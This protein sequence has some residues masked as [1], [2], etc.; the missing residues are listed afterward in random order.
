MSPAGGFWPRL[1]A[2]TRKEFR[3]M[4][5]DR[6]NL[7]IGLGLPIILI[8]LFGYG[9]SLDV[10]NTPVAIVLEDRSPQ[11][12]AAV[13][14]LLASSYIAPVLLPSMHEAEALM[15]ER[16]VDGILRLRSDFS[17]QLAAGDAHVQLLVHG[18]DANRARIVLAYVQGA[19]AQS[20][21][22][23]VDRNGRPA[24]G[25]QVTVEPQMWFNAASDS[26]W[27][28]V[29][30]LIVLI[31]TLVGAFLT[32]MVVAREWERGTL[33]A[34]FVTPVRPT[35]ILLAKLIPYFCVGMAG[36]TMCLLAAHFLFQVPCRGS[37]PLLVAGSVI[38]LLVALGMGLLI[39]S[40]TKNQFVASQ[41]ALVTS[42]MPA[43]MLSG[44]MFD[45]RSVP[46]VIRWVGNLLPATYYIELL[47]TLFLAGDVWPLLLKDLAV[48]T[49]YAAALLAAARM[50]TRKKLV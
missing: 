32:A 28:L 37:L 40:A 42:F 33:E 10:K 12:M 24:P 36:L 31:M 43:V 9:L 6:S 39:S 47:K 20:A 19:L 17:S 7:G 38:Y 15:R 5:R 46:A 35:E 22:R 27:F 34:L 25:G 13:S 2:L 4:V 50:V 11:A 3:Q 14:G 16:K 49:L 23:Q 1:F 21:L 26:T 45:L 18:A 41:L 48:L 29:P 30:G 8:L 44:F